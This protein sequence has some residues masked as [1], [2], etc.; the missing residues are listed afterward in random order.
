[1]SAVF[2]STEGGKVHGICCY[3]SAVTVHV[4]AAAGKPHCFIF[5]YSSHLLKSVET[6]EGDCLRSTLE[7]SRRWR[8]QKLETMS[9]QRLATS[10][11]KG[12]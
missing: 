6:S 7:R 5:N 10:M 1:M 9:S 8:C 11:S 2:R 4:I 3:T 12:A